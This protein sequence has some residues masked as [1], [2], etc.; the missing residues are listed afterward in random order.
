MRPSS[1]ELFADLDSLPGAAV[2]A[3]DDN[4]IMGINSQAAATLGWEAVSLVGQRLILLIPDELRERHI[5]GFTTFLLNGQS[6][7]IGT[8]A[9]VSALTGQCAGLPVELRISVKHSPSGRTVFIAELT[10]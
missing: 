5:A 10:R 1:G 6:R 4:R 2:A 7:I 3:D 9:R 8:P